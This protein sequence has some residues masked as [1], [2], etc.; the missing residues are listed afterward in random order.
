MAGSENVTS[1]A[2]LRQ[3]LG[4]LHGNSFVK[5]GEMQDACD[6]LQ[7]LIK[8]IDEEIG[9][10]ETRD[11][12][13]H[14]P[15]CVLKRL[16]GKELFENRFTYSEDGGCSTCGYRLRNTEED[17]RVLH[18][19]N[20]NLKAASIQDLLDE[21]LGHPSSKF[22]YKCRCGV[23]KNV[24][25]WKSVSNLPEVLLLT[26]PKFEAE[27]KSVSTDE[28]LLLNGVQY[29]LVSVMD[30]MGRDRHRGHWITWSRCPDVPSGWIRCDDTCIEA[31]QLERVFSSNN[32]TFA[33]VK[34][35][36]DTAVLDSEPVSP[37]ISTPPSSPPS[38][39]PKISSPSQKITTVSDTCASCG[40]S[41]KRLMTHLK[42]SENCQ[43]LYDMEALEEEQ[44]IKRKE[45][46][47]E[48]VKKSI[49]N[50]PEKKKAEIERVRAAVKK[51]VN[52]TPEKKKDEI[53]RVR[54][55]VDK[56]RKGRTPEKKKV[57]QIKNK[58][59]LDKHRKG[60]TPDKK[61]TD[62][63]KNK[64]ALD[65]H[66]KGR[67]PDK[68]ETDQIKN[69]E[70][71]DKHRKG[72]T[73]EKKKA[74]QIK[75]KET[76]DK[77]RKGRTPDKK[78]T[79]QIKNKEAVDK[80]RKGQTPEEVEIAKKKNREAHEARRKQLQNDPNYRKSV[81]V[82]K[83]EYRSKIFKKCNESVFG[84][85]RVF[86]ENVRF[87]PSFPCI[88]CHRRLFNISVVQIDLQKFEKD[89]NDVH[90]NIF[91]DTIHFKTPSNKN[92]YY[93]CFTCKSYIFKGQKPPMAATNNLEVFDNKDHPELQLTELEG[94]M[95]AKTLFF[96]KI[97]KLPRSDMSALKSKCVCI[98][99]GETDIQNTLGMLPRTPNQAG[100]VPVKL[101]RMQ[102]W[103]NVHLQQ[104]VNVEKLLKAL[105][106]LRDLG[107][108]YYQF[109]F[110]KNVQ[111]FKKRCMNEDKD[112]F[113]I[114]YQ[115]SDDD[116][117]DSADNVDDNPTVKS[118]SPNEDYLKECVNDE[119][120]KSNISSSNSSNDQQMEK[121]KA[122]EIRDEILE[123]EDEEEYFLKHDAVG[124]FMFNYNKTT[125]MSNDLPEINAPD[126]PVIISPGEGRYLRNILDFW[127]KF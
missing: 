53:E 124:K 99:I 35:T 123:R 77:H 82:A 26:V 14:I 122:E 16:E 49:N 112:G 45:N 89:V 102:K 62:Q 91:E 76:L 119:V 83:A 85:R 80:H 101:K 118:S 27:T 113:D 120:D 72:R 96:L 23:M 87:G 66:R 114:M 28:F 1:A 51:C 69:A 24:E 32:H 37:V 75:N 90:E 41:F 15:I 21:N 30:H 73:P 4:S 74:D 31:V 29:Q 71:L 22:Q 98:P 38:K 57:D 46:H 11:S 40:K 126:A 94:S 33:Y 43:L 97:F 47:R 79:D 3:D 103:K 50:T 54:A 20:K 93:I 116:L 13:N 36:P 65:K 125:A 7:A 39:R 107:H 104:Y 48:A 17:F 63:I 108:K 68:K 56:H 25:S 86:I 78:E 44:R 121:S 110:E 9:C 67:T 105:T 58:E 19:P 95:I 12:V 6:F 115:E 84:R 42:K 106:L 59:A 111:T 127:R 34:V 18:L 70:A 61:E 64:E 109:P 100:L 81:A 10:E 117:S 8:A 5:D 88:C 55:A 92:K 60:R 52:K 2:V